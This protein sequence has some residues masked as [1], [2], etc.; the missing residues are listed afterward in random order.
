VAE[1]VPGARRGRVRALAGAESGP[2]GVPASPAPD[3]ARPRVAYVVSRFPK[4][5]ETFVLYEILAVEAHGVR[6]DLYPLQRERARTLH[7]EAHRLV[8]RAHFTPWLSV[9]IAR[10][11]LHY[12][13][14][15]PLAYLR[16][17]FDLVRCNLGSPRYL[18][19][20]LA[21]F[22]KAVH[23][24]RR[25]AVDRVEHV[26]AHFASHPA[27]V[28]FAIRRLEGIPYSFTAH[29]SDLHRDQHML[30]EKVAES[31]FVVP[32]SEYNR[33]M[34]LDAC[35]GAHAEKLDVIHCGIDPDVFR[36]APRPLRGAGDP[37]RLVCIGTLHEVKG[38]AVL[39][40]ACR[41][42]AERGIAFRCD[43]VGDGPDRGALAARATAAGIAAQVRLHGACTRDQV[44]AIVR[45]AD[46]A[47]VPSVP[48][49]DGRR[50][51]IPVAL[52]EAAASGKPVVASRLSG[53]PEAIE[54]GEQGLL[55]PPGDAQALADALATLASDRG[56]C[57]RLG[58]AARERMLAEFDQRANAGRLA[59]RF[60]ESVAR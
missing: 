23:L 24:A 38:Q 58:A 35:V 16:T 4:L 59:A 49:R 10:S 36:P 55:F 44:A 47:V 42:L 29:G 9:A 18:A 11:Q 14:R 39:I 2:D 48:T 20:A 28:A 17:L 33:R 43:L 40:E 25:M 60:R 19:G 34:I 22:P 6:V 13:R 46:V 3:G 27:A 54:H 31:A 5:S 53:I 51:G 41:R 32:I 7:P 50:E 8:A 1:A 37:L 45:E 57:R 15:R 56:L 21:F 52:M 30:R 26:H 12:L